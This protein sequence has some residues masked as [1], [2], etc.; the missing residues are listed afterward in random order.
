MIDYKETKYLVF[1][2]ESVPDARLISQVKYPE[3]ELEDTAAVQKFQVRQVAATV[4]ST[5]LDLRRSSVCA[6]QGSAALSHTTIRSH[7][8]SAASGSSAVRI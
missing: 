6:W 5:M 3:E 1:D 4:K 8:R 7:G 2:V